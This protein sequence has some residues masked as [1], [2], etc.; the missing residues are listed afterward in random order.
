MA[1]KKGVRIGIKKNTK[2]YKGVK[3]GVRKKRG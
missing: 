1:R 3:S 2:K